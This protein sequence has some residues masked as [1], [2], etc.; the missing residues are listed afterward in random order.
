MTYDHLVVDGD[1]MLYRAYFKFGQFNS[2]AGE[3][4]GIIFGLPYM[5]RGLLTKVKPTLVSVAFDGGRDKARTDILPGYK[6][7][8]PKLNFDKEAFDSQKAIVMELLQHMNCMVVWKKGTEADDHIYSLARRGTAGGASTCIVSADKDFHQLISDSVHVWYPSKEIM[9][10]PKN[11]HNYFPYKPEEALQYLC[12]TGD[13]SDKIPGVPG[14]GEKRARQFMDGTYKYSNM[15]TL[16]E[17]VKR[18]KKLIDLRHH[19]IF[20]NRGTKVPYLNEKPHFNMIEIA[21]V[22][23]RFDCSTLTKVDFITG[24]KELGQ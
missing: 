14:I 20:H 8:E 11:L 17:T 4:S 1:N 13:D 21:K 19:W 15:K 3:P 24:F 2:K 6:I 5:L 12:L 9:L 7:R 22:A 10:T 23:R 16:Q 18:N